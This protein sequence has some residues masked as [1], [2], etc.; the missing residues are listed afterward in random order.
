[1]HA[2]S[3]PLALATILALVDGLTLAASG[4]FTHDFH[5]NVIRTHLLHGQ[6]SEREQVTVARITAGLVGLLSIWLAAR[7]G[8]T[9]NAAAFVAGVSFELY[10]AP[11]PPAHLSPMCLTRF[12]LTGLS[13]LRV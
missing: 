9:A 8:A 12:Q 3:A 1:M 11:N 13:T 7:V 4:A 6:V 10:P 2:F 5:V